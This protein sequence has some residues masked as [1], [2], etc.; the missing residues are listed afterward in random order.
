MD[1][2]IALPIVVPEAS[3]TLATT[4]KS[5]W[6]VPDLWK[7]PQN[8][9]SHKVLGRRKERAAHNAPQALSFTN[10]EEE[11]KIIAP[12]AQEGIRDDHHF[13]ASLR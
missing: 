12:R 1:R 6:I 7:T 10:E 13:V 8:G 4:E 5:L 2:S 3:W 9:V 11:R